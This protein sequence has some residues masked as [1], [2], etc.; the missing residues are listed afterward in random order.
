MNQPRLSA[1]RNPARSRRGRRT[2]PVA[3]CNHGQLNEWEMVNILEGERWALGRQHKN[4][5]ANEFVCNLHK[6]MFGKT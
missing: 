5:L 4:L 2:D 6:R 3:H 1:R